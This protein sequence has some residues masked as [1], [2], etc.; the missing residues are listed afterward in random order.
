[1]NFSWITYYLQCMCCRKNTTE[2]EKVDSVT[3]RNSIN[4][5]ITDST[6]IVETNNDSMCT[7]DSFYTNDS[8]HGETIVT[9]PIV[10]NQIKTQTIVV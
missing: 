10:I 1:M 4:V 5:A 3:K 8:L 9:N 7:N 6:F 2:E